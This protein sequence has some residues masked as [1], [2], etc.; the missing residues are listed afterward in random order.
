MQRHVVLQ[1][2]Y[3]EIYHYLSGPTQSN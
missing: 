1:Y 2:T 3:I